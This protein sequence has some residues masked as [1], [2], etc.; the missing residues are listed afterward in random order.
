MTDLEIQAEAAADYACINAHT[1]PFRETIDAWLVA[2][3]A[4]I[5]ADDIVLACLCA[6]HRKFMEASLART[7]WEGA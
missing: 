2:E 7:I 1:K 4:A 6:L 5:E 3:D